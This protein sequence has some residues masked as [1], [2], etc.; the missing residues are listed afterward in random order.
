MLEDSEGPG[1]TPRLLLPSQPSL[2]SHS[3]S[4]VGLEGLIAGCLPRSGSLRT[5]IEKRENLRQALH[6]PKTV[7]SELGVKILLFNSLFHH[8]PGISSFVCLLMPGRMMR[9]RASYRELITFQIPCF[10]DNL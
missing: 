7:E 9:S 8:R 5:K 1:E 3:L 2:T 4:G 10:P 6:N